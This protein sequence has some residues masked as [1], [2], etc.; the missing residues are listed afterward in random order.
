MKFVASISPKQLSHLA[1]DMAVDLFREL[2]WA[3]ANRAGVGLGS[4]SVPSAINV[5]DG[6]VDAEIDGVVAAKAGGLLHSGL[7]RYQIKT[8][9][10]S[11]G[12]KTE[13]RELFFK[14]KSRK[15]KDRVQ[16]C[17]EKRGTFVVV[18]FGSDTPNRIDDEAT[19]ACRQIVADV[20]PE[21][22]DCKIFIITQNQLAGFLNQYPPLA[23]KARLRTFQN[24]KRHAQWRNVLE[25]LPSL[26]VGK[27]QELFI[28]QVR[29]ELQRSL[30]THICIWGEPG[31]GKTRLLYEATA[32]ESL[33]PLIAYFTSPKSMK[34]SGIID[35]LAENQSSS[36]II[37]VDDCDSRDRVLIWRELKELGPRA[38]LITVQHDPCESSVATVALQAPKLDDA[39]VSNIIQQHGIDKM[40]ADRFADYCGGSP[41]VADMVGWN[42]K[43]NPDDLTR[44]LDTENVWDRFIQGSESPTSDDV[45]QREL[46]LHYL[47]LFKKFGYG[48]P[49]QAEAMAIA[50]QVNA[51]NGLISWQ[52]FQEIIMKLRE[53]RILQ[54][55]TTL[56]ITPKLLHIKLWS[57]WWKRYGENSNVESLI[58]SYPQSMHGWFYDMFSYA[59]GSSAVSKTVRVILSKHSAFFRNHQIKSEVG[60]NFFL[61][62]TEADT[63]AA[64]EFLE[65]TIGKESNGELRSFRGG[66]QRVVWALE[67]IAVERALFVRA[68]RLLLRLAETENEPIYANNASGTF[69]NLFSLGPGSTA[70]TQASPSERIVVLE[71]AISS[72]QKDTRAVALRAFEVALKSHSFSRTIGAERR[73]LKDLELWSPKTYGE[74]FDAYRA[75]WRLLVSQLKS[76]PDDEFAEAVRILLLRS[77]ELVQIENLAELVT[78]TIQELIDDPRVQRKAVL[79]MA[80]DVEERLIELPDPIKS[81]WEMIRKL[82]AGGDSFRGRLRS[83]LVLPPW[84]FASDSTLTTEAWRDIAAEA[85]SSPKEF[86]DELPWLVS[87]EPESAGP[88]GYELGRL[89]Q[90]LMFESLI[91]SVIADA[92]VGCN[93]NLLAGYLRAVQER[94]YSHWLS[95]VKRL[96]SRS[97]SELFF[98]NVVTQSSLTDELADILSGLIEKGV[99]PAHYLQAFVFGGAIANL[100]PAKFESWIVLLLAKQEKK[101]VVVALQLLHYYFLKHKRVNI[102]PELIEAVMLNETLFEEESEAVQS[103][104]DYDW[105]EVA[106]MYLGDHPSRKM[107]VAKKILD[108]AGRDS[109]VVKRFTRSYVSKLLNQLVQEMP[110]EMWAIVSPMLGP[111]I[112]KRAHALADWLQGGSFKFSVEDEKSAALNLIPQQSIWEWVDQDLENR[113]WY[114]ASFAPKLNEDGTLPSLVRAILSRYGDRDDVKESLL[115]NWSSEGWLGPASS[116][117]GSKKEVLERLLE[118][119]SEPRVREWL[120]LYIRRLRLRIETARRQEERED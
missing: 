106:K 51:A 1:P 66:R 110:F 59:H 87:N 65:A 14:G 21:F 74:W 16:T 120:H 20:K 25:R 92:G 60:A 85:L 64:L 81:K 62:L 94:D 30:A 45:K 18:L 105:A 86:L 55:D 100:S 10:F 102:S 101:S 84:R 57:E 26:Q 98:P 13:I 104:R 103:H 11:A 6:G 90:A 17:F 40:T 97:D 67:K 3:E 72:M 7:T 77:F 99:F 42:L 9:A 112:D 88:F 19:Q 69:A 78:S 28:D 61:S 39:E 33:S 70:P 119:E 48:S 52:R 35:E 2:L 4:V 37:V 83:C 113:A 109:I 36:A 115:S 93:A 58:E 27:P 118:T 46:V 76:L 41:R 50:S 56:Y 24:L 71:E 108:S 44:P 116:H 82:A 23:D 53:R 73:G 29:A 91:V 43:N 111:P 75:V 15:F 79:E 96:S 117:Y 5:S 80:L 8:G 68:A 89:D 31:I 114:L 95:T 32:A 34:D 47:A 49:Y 63:E 12:N 107:I 22:K 54:G 38:R